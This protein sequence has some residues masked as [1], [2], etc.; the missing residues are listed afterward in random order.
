MGRDLTVGVISPYSC[1]VFGNSRP[2]QSSSFSDVVA[3]SE[4]APD[5]WVFWSH[6][7]TPHGGLR[8]VR[9]SNPKRCKKAANGLGDVLDVRDRSPEFGVGQKTHCH[10][11]KHLESFTGSGAV[12]DKATTLEK[13]EDCSGR[14]LPNTWQLYGEMTPTDLGDVF[15]LDVS[16]IAADH[17]HRKPHSKVQQGVGRQLKH[18]HRHLRVDDQAEVV[19]GG[20]EQIYAPFHDAFRGGVVGAVVGDEVMDGRCAYTRMEVHPPVA[21]EL[22]VRPVGDAHPRAFVTVDVHRHDRKQETQHCFT[23]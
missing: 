22:S 14:E 13:L 4:T 10:G 21:E 3:L 1:H 11:K 8:S 16:T 9:N 17:V 23:P 12:A 7:L 18:N 2:E 6:H 19:A 5:P 15:Q 20:G